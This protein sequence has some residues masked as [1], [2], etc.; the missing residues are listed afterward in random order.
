L[1]LRS[2]RNLQV[3]ALEGPDFACRIR[4]ARDLLG[5]WVM[6]VDR[7]PE[8]LLPASA[9]SGGPRLV[10]RWPASAAA[11]ELS[12]VVPVYDEAANVRPLLDEIHAA[13]EG[14]VAYEVV[15]V[16][17]GSRDATLDCLRAAMEDHP[18][19]VVVRHRTR[20][21]QSAALHTGVRTARGTWIATLDGDGQ[22][23][24]ADIPRLLAQA[25]EMGGA[26]L[27][28][29]HRRVRHDAWRKRIASRL[30][31]AV[32]RALL[33]DATPDTG[34]GLKVFSRDTFLALPCFDHMH[35]FLPA[36]F[37]AQGARVAVADVNH[38]PRRAGHSKYGTLDRA[39]VGLV[40]L[41]GVFWLQRRMVR[42]DGEVLT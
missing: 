41:F 30:A 26:T 19:L 34:C 27:V 3:D 12:V 7:P 22:N 15:F 10:S 29:G 2:R 11:T 37:R 38:R 31:N 6:R 1:A 16:D 23:D 20:C 18:R 9:P 39:L 4:L 28:A 35:R 5:E 40:D 24:P 25:R 8:R 13:L 17:D 14:G 21:G 36:L 42:P 32:R 33:R